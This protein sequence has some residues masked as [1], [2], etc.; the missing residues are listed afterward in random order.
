MVSNKHTSER[1]M[2]GIAAL[3]DECASL[4]DLLARMSDEAYQAHA[5]GKSPIGA[6]VRHLLDHGRAVLQGIDSGIVDYEQRQRG[7]AVEQDRALAMSQLERLCM[8]FAGCSVDHLARTVQVQVM[9]RSDGQLGLCPSTI[10]REILFLLSHQ[11]HHHA[12]IA[13]VASRHAVAVDPLFA[14]APSTRA[15]VIQQQQQ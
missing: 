4:R 10:E 8:D 5:P 1:A 3:L 9:I 13:E 6:H 2:S 15:A 11:H 7:A 14:L 12:V